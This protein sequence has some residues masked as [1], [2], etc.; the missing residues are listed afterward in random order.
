MFQEGE[1]AEEETCQRA[2]EE[3]NKEYFYTN[4]LVKE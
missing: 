1:R 3:R 4:T 2:T